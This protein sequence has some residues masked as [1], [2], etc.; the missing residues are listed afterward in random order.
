MTALPGRFYGFAIAPVAWALTTQLG[1]ILPYADCAARTNWTLAACAGALTASAAGAVAAGR[2][3]RQWSPSQRK[4]GQTF[5][6][7]ALVFVFAIC[8]QGAASMLLSPC[9]R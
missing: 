6:A 4:F 9:A 7:I 3:W 2:H 1:Q 5:L 8:L